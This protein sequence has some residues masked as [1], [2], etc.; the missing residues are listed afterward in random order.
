[1]PIHDW[2]RVHPGVFHDFHLGWIAGLWRALNGGLLPSDHYA[3]I[4]EPPDPPLGGGSEAETYTRRRRTLVIRHVRDDR[5]VALIEIVSPGNKAGRH[6]F[7]TFV[8]TA[9]EPLTLA[10]YAALPGGAVRAHVE[11]TA[12]GRGMPPMLAF[13]T[14]DFSVPVPLEETYAAAFAGVPAKYRTALAG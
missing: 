5:V 11:P 13:L 1:M 8:E 3:G 4:A 7:R 2:T 14:A 9:D 6:A 10:G 12:V